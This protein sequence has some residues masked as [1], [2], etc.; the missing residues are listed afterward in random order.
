MIDFCFTKAI[1]TT[2]DK[3][4]LILGQYER[5]SGQQVNRDK[6]PI[7]FSKSIPTPTKNAIKDLLN[8]S[9][10]RQYEKYLGLPSLIGRNQ[11]KSFI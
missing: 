11:A 8:V 5:A 7:F 4:Q 9:I 1:T 6:T 10:I 2:C 3:I